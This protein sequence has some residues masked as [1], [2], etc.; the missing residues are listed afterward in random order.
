MRQSSRRLFLSK[1]QVCVYIYIY[2]Y[3]YIYCII[4]Y[5]IYIYIYIIDIFIHIISLSRYV[6]IYIYIYIYGPGVDFP[7]GPN[8]LLLIENPPRSLTIE[9]PL[10]WFLLRGII[11]DRTVIGGVLGC[12]RFCVKGRLDMSARENTVLNTNTTHVK[13][14]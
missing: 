3:T 12:R 11:V 5:Y 9:T 14:L 1:I 7:E 10:N 2:I 8:L 4:L 6:Y 13:I